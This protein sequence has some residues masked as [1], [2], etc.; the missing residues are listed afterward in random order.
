[1]GTRERVRPFVGHPERDGDTG[2]NGCGLGC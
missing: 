1:M 2:V